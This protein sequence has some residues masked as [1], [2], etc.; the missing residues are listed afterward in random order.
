MRQMPIK[1]NSLSPPHTPHTHHHFKKEGSPYLSYYEKG[2][3]AYRSF[4]T[5]SEAKSFMDAVGKKNRLPGDMNMST[6][7]LLKFAKFRALCNDCKISVEQGFLKAY[8]VIVE[9]HKVTE[10]SLTIGEGI[11]QFL[12]LC[13]KTNSRDGTTTDYLSYTTCITEYFGDSRKISRIIQH[14]GNYKVG[15]K[16]VFY[17]SDIFKIIRVYALKLKS[18]IRIYADI[19][20][21]HEFCQSVTVNQNDLVLDIFY[22]IKRGLAEF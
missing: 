14:D 11:R 8:D 19:V 17:K 2:K 21:Y 13:Q 10:D 5:R 1:A 15:G 12:L 22:I 20:F 3:R 7:D 18:L 9:K 16:G 6:L 4:K